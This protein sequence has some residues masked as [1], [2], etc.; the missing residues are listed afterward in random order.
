MST[1]QPLPCPVC[2]DTYSL[3]AITFAYHALTTS[4]EFGVMFGVDDTGDEYA[5]TC[6]SCGTTLGNLSAP[7]LTEHISDALARFGKD[8]VVS[9]PYT[10]TYTCRFASQ[11]PLPK[12]AVVAMIQYLLY[13][14]GGSAGTFEV[15]DYWSDPKVVSTRWKVTITRDAEQDYHRD[16]HENGHDGSTKAGLAQLRAEVAEAGL[17]EHLKVERREVVEHEEDALAVN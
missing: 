11:T 17:G 14:E 13:D 7:D 3:Q 8:S 15:S 5:L 2:G 6:H 16:F 12:V 9:P 4:P 10:A 1:E